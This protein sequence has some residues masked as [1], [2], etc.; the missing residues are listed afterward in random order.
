[1]NLSKHA[2]MTIQKGGRFLA[3]RL[4][5]AP[6]D[7]LVLDNT[8][9]LNEEIFGKKMN[10]YQLYQQENIEIFVEWCRVNRVHYYSDCDEE[11]NEGVGFEQAFDKNCVAVILD[12][13]S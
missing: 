4:H 10:G 12:N 2:R 8:D 3:W 1:M 11:F 13:L 9:A 7:L 6:Y 5:K